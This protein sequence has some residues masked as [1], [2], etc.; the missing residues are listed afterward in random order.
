[1]NG[2]NETPNANRI[3]IG[4]FGKRNAGKSS[5]MNAIAGQSLAI[6]SPEKGTTTDPVSKA[7]E[8]LP[9]GPVVFIDT[10]GL[11]DSG[12][13]GEKRVEKSLQ[14]LNRID[15][16][17]LVA[18]NPNPLEGSDK[19]LLDSIIKRKLPYLIVRNMADVF[20]P[21]SEPADNEIYV[22]AQTGYNIDALKNRLAAMSP[23]SKNPPIISD[24]VKNGD[25]VVLVMPI[26]SGAPKGRLILPQQQT[27]RELLDSGTA[28]IAVQ[29][30][31]LKGIVSL[32]GEKIRMVVTDSQVF[33]AVNSILPPSIPLTSFSILFARYKGILDDSIKGIKAIDKLQ[34]N[35][36]VLISEGCTH[37]RQCDDIGTVKIPGWLSEYTGKK[38]EFSYTNGGDFPNTLS[39]YDVIV[40][41]GGCMLNTGEV[42]RRMGEAK[43]AGVP[44]TNFGLLIA[45]LNGIL[46]RSSS[47][48]KF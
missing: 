27:I 2:L 47:L 42:M 28:A 4:I 31:Q 14:V 16:A 48:L 46:E 21:A 12:E 19:M 43:K 33:G 3:Q 10:P 37:H 7:M 39:D 20:P 29:V 8:L 15:I 35:S 24:L 25:I 1:M 41:C 11:D 23:A 5:L 6:V 45:H 38:L 26:D 44:M 36:R 34:D 30:E 17:L 32:L 13:L 22:S 9:L 40:H 18:D